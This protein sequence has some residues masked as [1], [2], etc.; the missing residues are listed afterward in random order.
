MSQQM[1]AM[2]VDAASVVNNVLLS[3]AF[4]PELYACPGLCDVGFIGILH[5]TD[6]SNLI[7]IRLEVADCNYLGCNTSTPGKNPR[8]WSTRKIGFGPDLNPG[9]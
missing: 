9:Y 5:C 4:G 3:I 7:H 1:K 8:P 2:N 6:S